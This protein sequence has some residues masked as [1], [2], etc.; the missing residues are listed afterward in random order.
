IPALRAGSRKAVSNALSAARQN[1]LPTRRQRRIRKV[2]QACQLALTLV[3]LIGSALSL[4]SFITL[5]RTPDGFQPASLLHVSLTF[6]TG[7]FD[8]GRRAALL[9]ELSLRIGALPGV[10]AAAIGPAPVSD[11]YSADMW[12]PTGRADR[13]VVL[14]SQRFAVGP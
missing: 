11:G 7:E 10:S 6:P 13:A 9:N 1:S 5:L 3:L 2:F 12:E 4:A 8:Q 14:H